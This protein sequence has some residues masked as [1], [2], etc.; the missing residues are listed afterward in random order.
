[1]IISPNPGRPAL[2]MIGRVIRRRRR[3]ASAGTLETLASQTSDLVSELL[4]QNRA[5]RAENE[6]LKRDVERLSAGWDEIK[7]L[8]KLAPR[9]K[10]A[11]IP[12]TRKTR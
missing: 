9:R 3:Q 12:L 1:M 2:S 8:A 11:R 7:R 5:L 6:A 10:Q 4:V